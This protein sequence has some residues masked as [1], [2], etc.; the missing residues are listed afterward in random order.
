MILAALVILGV[1][2]LLNYW[3]A[4]SIRNTAF[5]LSSKIQGL[6]W[7]AGE[8][9]ASG[10]AGL[11]GSYQSQQEI[12]TLQRTNYQLLKKIADLETLRQENQALRQALNLDLPET[13]GLIETKPLSRFT[14][15]DFILLDKGASDGVEQGMPVV[16]AEGVA[17]A[18]VDKVFTY[19]SQ[20]MLLTNPQ[21][22]FDVQILPEN[23]EEPVLGVV[24]GRG[25]LRARFQM[26]PEEQDIAKGDQVITSAL[27]NIFPQ[28]LLVGQ[29]L[30]I[31]KDPA[32]PFQQGE[33]K[34]YFLNPFPKHLFL[35]KKSSL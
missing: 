22:K 12:E 15:G 24:K 6:F 17:V 14:E 31:E 1:L 23:N 8:W 28:G 3:G 5:F 29:V 4:S 25:G 34:V 13:T 26:V 35:L 33:V 32:R 21:M 18:R 10:I 9:I 20:A 16:S 30:R 27:G 2:F 7:R 11:T 19:N